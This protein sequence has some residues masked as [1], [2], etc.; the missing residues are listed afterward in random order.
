MF[1]PITVKLDERLA[2]RVSLSVLQN[3]CSPNQPHGLLSPLRCVLTQDAT[4]DAALRELFE[5]RIRAE[6]SAP[7]LRVRQ[8]GTSRVPLNEGALRARVNEVASELGIPLQVTD[9]QMR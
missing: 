6:V 5:R 8:D 2:T 1:L 7:G 3:R 9:G 4:S